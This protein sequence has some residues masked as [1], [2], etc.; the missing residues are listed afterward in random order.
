MSISCPYLRPASRTHRA[1]DIITPEG[2]P[3]STPCSTPAELPVIHEPMPVCFAGIV[4]PSPTCSSP[5]CDK[6]GGSWDIDDMLGWT[7]MGGDIARFSLISLRLCVWLCGVIEVLQLEGVRQGDVV[8][9]VVGPRW[10]CHPPVLIIA[11][12]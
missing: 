6:V 7:T 4:D 11:V 10:G 1:E 5:E 8:V 9:V 12:S 2:S 3:Q